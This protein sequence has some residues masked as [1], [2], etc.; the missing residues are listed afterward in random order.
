MEWTWYLFRFRGPHQPRQILDG[1]LLNILGLMML[2]SLLTI[3][4][5]ANCSAVRTVR[6]SS[7]KT[8]SSFG[9][10]FVPVADRADLSRLLIK[11]FGTSLLL[12]VYFAT[13]IK[14]LHDRD[15]SGWWMMPF[16]VFPGLFDQFADR[17]A[18][19][20]AR[21]PLAIAAFVLCSVGLHRDVFP[22]GLAQDQPV[23]R[24]PAG[25]APIDTRPPWDQQSEIEMVPHKAG[26][27]P[28]WRV[29]RGMNDAVSIARD[30]VRCPSVTPADA[31]ALGVLENLLKAAGFEVHRVT[32]GE[33]GTADIDNLYARIGNGAPHI[34]FAGHTDVVPP[35]D[36][37]AWT[38]WR[39]LGRRQG[40]LSL[41]PRRRRHEGRHRLQR[42]RGAGISRRQWRQAKEARSRS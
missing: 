42:R 30:L 32:F 12:W 41:W 9:S 14:R 21:L 38:P 24:R 6:F 22:Q 36:E 23:R 17:L 31:G 10:R 4:P 18:D 34:T 20:Y 26:P 33:P 15:K 1:D 2:L 29:K 16:F 5:S 25:A 35:G 39:V 7:L 11:L 19:S 28:V 27:P 3:A 37:A 13:S 8:S 40:R